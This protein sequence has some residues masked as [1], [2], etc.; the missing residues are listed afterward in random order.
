MAPTSVHMFV[1]VL[2]CSSKT[3]A[4][5]AFDW[6]DKVSDAQLMEPTM[7]IESTIKEFKG[8]PISMTTLHSNPQWVFKDGSI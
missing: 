7:K 1:Q 3:A 5:Y 6:G 2:V 8:A 4:S